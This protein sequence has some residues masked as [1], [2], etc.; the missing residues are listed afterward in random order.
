MI[1]K[2]PRDAQ[3]S[4][5]IVG[6]IGPVDGPV[7]IGSTLPGGRYKSF[8][9]TSLAGPSV[10]GMARLI[11]ATL[12]EKEEYVSKSPV[13]SDMGFDEVGVAVEELRAVQRLGGHLM[14]KF[15][16]A[17]GYR[18]VAVEKLTFQTSDMG[19]HEAGEDAFAFPVRA[20]SVHVKT[21]THNFLM[22][23]SL[24]GEKTTLAVWDI[25]KPMPDVWERDAEKNVLIAP[26]TKP[27]KPTPPGESIGYLF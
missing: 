17:H 7:D 23:E 13:A 19:L 16:V 6:G 25:D 21:K 10:A 26:G 1:S 14:E 3:D 12:G 18:K 22:R 9:G 4:V 24:E 8:A 15:G 2:T 27:V 20:R 5:D 11:D